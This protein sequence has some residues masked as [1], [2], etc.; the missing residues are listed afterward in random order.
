VLWEIELENAAAADKLQAA[1]SQL[2]VAMTGVQE[3]RHL[4][5]TRPSPVR[6]RFLNTFEAATAAALGAD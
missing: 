2:V 6:V 5:I 4:K 3:K 1:A